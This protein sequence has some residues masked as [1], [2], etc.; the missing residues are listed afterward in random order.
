MDP[1]VYKPPGYNWETG[2]ATALEASPAFFNNGT[3]ASGAVDASYWMCMALSAKIMLLMSMWALRDVVGIVQ[4]LMALS[5]AIM[6]LQFAADRERVA[7]AAFLTVA[8]AG[9]SP[10]IPSPPE[11]RLPF[12]SRRLHD[13]AV[14]RAEA[15]GLVPDVNAMESSRMILPYVSLVL[16]QEVSPSGSAVVQVVLALA[17]ELLWPSIVSA[18]VLHCLVLSPCIAAMFAA[19][20]AVVAIEPVDGKNMAV[21]VAAVVSLLLLPLAG[22]LG[23]ASGS[24]DL[25]W[26]LVV[27]WMPL[28]LLCFCAHWAASHEL[29]EDHWIIGGFG[30]LGI[31]LRYTFGLPGIFTVLFHRFGVFAIAGNVLASIITILPAVVMCVHIVLSIVAWLSPTPGN[32]ILRML[33]IVADKI[34]VVRGDSAWEMWSSA[35]ELERLEMS[36]TVV[37][38]VTVVVILVMPMMFGRNEQAALAILS[39]AH[40]GATF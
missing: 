23:P 32:R 6:W 1:L 15:F 40:V 25:G 21:I 7:A 39:F 35:R 22:F 3:Q 9:E 31:V 16:A 28:A 19:G 5:A 30:I 27:E 34:H 8:H 37:A 4:A 20:A 36:T 11:S 12:R 29:G 10:E 18:I 26:L 38:F 13:P 33:R 24:P 2:A 17:A 14:A